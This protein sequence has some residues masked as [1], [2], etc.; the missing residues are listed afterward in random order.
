[1]SGVATIAR[2]DGANKFRKIL[3]GDESWFMLECQHA[4]KWNLS[5]EDV[6]KE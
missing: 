4:V 5:C 3:T 1:M 6:S 2:K